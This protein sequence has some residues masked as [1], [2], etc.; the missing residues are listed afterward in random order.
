MQ[1][2]LSRGERFLA[3]GS[4]HDCSRTPGTCRVEGSRHFRP[5]TVQ[6]PAFPQKK[7]PP[8]PLR[9]GDR[10]TEKK[11]W[12]TPDSPQLSA[13]APC[14]QLH[15]VDRRCIGD[16]LFPGLFPAQSRLLLLFH[17]LVPKRLYFVQFF[18]RR[19]VLLRSSLS[20]ASLFGESQSIWKSSS[21]SSSCTNFFTSILHCVGFSIRAVF[22][23]V[24]RCRLRFAS[25]SRVHRI[26]VCM[27]SFSWYGQAVLGPCRLR[28]RLTPPQFPRW[29]EEGRPRG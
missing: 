27:P 7:N 25:H 10:G 23:V 20:S 8:N 13:P 17:E 22:K 29:H 12:S 1:E 2:T 3:I 19:G 11:F 6:A 28:R 21:I 4:C 24:K 18:L 5:R 26:S 14:S 16:H 9:S 15:L